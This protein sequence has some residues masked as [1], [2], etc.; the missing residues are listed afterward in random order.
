MALRFH[1]GLLQEELAGL[2]LDPAHVVDFSVNVN[3]Y[4]PAPAVA[5]AA[6]TAALDRYP[7]PTAWPLRQALA[8]KLDVAPDRI[9]VG[10]GAA[11]LFWTLARVLVRAGERALVVGPTFAEFPAAVRAAGGHVYEWRADEARAFAID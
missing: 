9:V 5:Q 4:G 6:R 7:D 1:G 8:R 2:D 3:P 11:D 10:S